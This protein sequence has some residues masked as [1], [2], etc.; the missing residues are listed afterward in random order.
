[1]QAELTLIRQDIHAHPEMGMEEVRTSALV[2]AKLKQWG[3]EV[4]E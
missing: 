4:T 1:M 3:V 2:A